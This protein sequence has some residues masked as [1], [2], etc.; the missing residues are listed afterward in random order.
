MNECARARGALGRWADGELPASESEWIDSHCEACA[1]CRAERDRFQEF[2]SRLLAVGN[3]IGLPSGTAAGR[4][5]RKAWIRVPAAALLAAGFLVSLWLP[6]GKPVAVD[7]G[8]VAVPFVPP[9]ARYE[10]SSVVS[11]EIPVADLLA[12]G[13]SV[14][15]DPA[16]VVPADVLLGEDGRMRA[17]RLA[18]ELM[19]KGAGE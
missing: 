16:S 3:S 17:V 12:E 18:P 1:E 6:Q 8:F 5:R 11:Q 4:D 9:V 10:R 13:F 19:L 2:D 7:D 14:E 15:A